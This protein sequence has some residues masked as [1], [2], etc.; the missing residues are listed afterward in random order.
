VLDLLTVPDVARELKVSRGLAYRLVREG[1][2]PA[3]RIS[4]ANIRVRRAD[5]VAY[6]EGRCGRS[7]G[8]GRE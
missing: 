2:I 3:V 8:G 6:V 5:L 4:E 7:G 1:E